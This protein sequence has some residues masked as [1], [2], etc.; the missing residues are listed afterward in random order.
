[1]ESSSS[2]DQAGARAPDQRAS[3]ADE[4]RTPLE[5]TGGIA[6][7][8]RRH[9]RA[10]LAVFLVT[11]ATGLVLAL[12]ASKQYEA[13]AQILLQPTD[14][15]TAA[16]SPDI[17]PSAANAQRDVDTYAK[18]ITVQP[19]AEAVRQKLRLKMSAKELVDHIQISGQ[20]DSNLVSIT[21]TD[22]RP[23]RA[24]RIATAFALSYREY[25]RQ[26]A[27]A[28]IAQSLAAGRQTLAARRHSGA[29]RANR[30]ALT[31]R[32]RDLEVAYATQTGGVQVVRRAEVPTEA[33]RRTLLIAGAAILIGLILAI[34]TA[35]LLNRLDR[36]LREPSD[37]EAALGVPVLGVLPAAT[38]R[39][40]EARV[41]ACADLAARLEFEPDS[42][43]A[44][45]MVVSCGRGL[46]ASEVAAGLAAQFAELGQRV[47]LIEAD[48]RRESAG[49][50]AAAGLTTL[51]AG[52]GTLLAAIGAL[53]IVT[54]AMGN[55]RSRSES[56]L[57][58]SYLSSGPPARNP[59]ALLG[60]P[61]LGQLLKQAAIPFDI[62]LVDCGAL[63]PVSDTAPV[64]RLCDDIL[65]VAE[66]GRMTHGDADETR[67][68]LGAHYRKVVGVAVQTA[69][70]RTQSAAPPRV[71]R[72][73]VQ[74]GP[75]SETGSGDPAEAGTNWAGAS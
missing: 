75:Q 54:Q 48:L 18:L 11:S 71:E 2:F 35:L 69:R 28:S 66:R 38:S 53:H 57:S 13:T 27:R 21:A 64:A 24:A 30:T 59:A 62:I 31:R 23:A 73:Q 63:L 34:A 15:M 10:A 29:S 46:A 45:L 65:L 74:P 17:V 42:R 32:L 60:R 36:R 50:P 39:Q 72:V 52:K 9:W 55:G 56:V 14:A 37:I 5:R 26:T 47:L 6:N 68:A 8:L 44:V 41:A 25:R 58:Y 16:V 12:Q 7:A 61:A 40:A 22:E 51:L 19:V 70:R 1:M 49:E 67:R 4:L 43:G 20:E 3:P 33:S